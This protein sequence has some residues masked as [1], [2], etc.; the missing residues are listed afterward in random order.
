[1]QVAI[2]AA[3]GAMIIGSVSTS[4]RSRLAAG[5]NRHRF[6]APVLRVP[7][8]LSTDAGV[9]PLMSEDQI[10]AAMQPQ[11]DRMRAAG[12]GRSEVLDSQVAVL[13]STSALYRVTSE[14]RRR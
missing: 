8:L 9:F 1:V 11:T 4:K 3:A 2:T 5:R 10:V 12:S 14:E 13:N 6:A 7:L